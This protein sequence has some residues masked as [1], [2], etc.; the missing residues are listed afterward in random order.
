MTA[1]IRSNDLHIRYTAAAEL[2]GPRFTELHPAFPPNCQWI[3]DDHLLFIDELDCDEPA[4]IAAVP[5]VYDLRTG[6]TR[7]LIDGARLCALL[8]IDPMRSRLC[9]FHVSSE[10][11]LCVTLG[12]ERWWIDCEHHHVSRRSGYT[13]ACYSPSGLWAVDVEGDGL[14]LRNTAGLADPIYLLPPAPGVRMGRRLRTNPAVVMSDMPSDIVGLWSPG[15][16]WFLTEIIDERASPE[17]VLV[18][19]CPPNRLRPLAHCVRRSLPGDTL[20]VARLVAVDVETGI[21]VEFDED[22]IVQ[23][24]TPIELGEIWF[25]GDESAFAI[26]YDRFWRSAEILRIDFRTIEIRSILREECDKGAIGF[27]RRFL[28]PPNVRSV[29]GANELVVY[30]E[31]SG[32]GQLALIDAHV[33]TIIRELTREPGVVDEIVHIDGDRRQVTYLAMGVDGGMDPARRTLCIVDLDSGDLRTIFSHNGDVAVPN[34]TA[35]TGSVATPHGRG[36]GVSPSGRHA[37]VHLGGVEAGNRSASVDLQTGEFHLLRH[38]ESADEQVCAHPFDALAADGRTRLDGIIFV[39]RN[40]DRDAL[41]PLI[42]FIYPGP[43]VTHRPQQD[44]ALAAA[45]ARAL[46]ALGFAVMMLDTRNMPIGDRQRHQAGHGR[47]VE[48]QIADHVAAIDALPYNFGFI[49]TANAGILGQSAGGGAAILAM[50]KYPGLFRAGVA[51]NGL[52]DPGHYASLWSDRFAG[53]GGANADLPVD[54]SAIAHVDGE[55]FLVASDSDANVPLAQTLGLAD[56]LIGCGKSFDMLIVPNAAHDMLMVSTYT[57]RRIWD[58]FCRHL[59]R[60]EPPS[61][62]SIEEPDAV[63]VALFRKFLGRELQL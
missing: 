22:F 10:H 21:V 26:R 53:P 52:Y 36:S 14:Q 37:L 27:N 42:D 9:D 57:Q 61:G 59:L 34:A 32:S 47:F 15:S 35:E 18:Q 43:Q 12:D 38:F 33:G 1:A 7:T 48:V 13:E 11:E 60:R 5:K 58:F 54:A 63:S 29:P 49:D 62:I 3:D 31:Q 20:P 45:P 41:L 16:R 23:G 24:F 19:H 39:P 51:V 40:L 56:Q 6:V 8:D 50:A 46:A 30:S 17:A 2:L 55:L 4:G 28:R 25:D 44:A